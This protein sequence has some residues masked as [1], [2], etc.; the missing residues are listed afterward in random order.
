LAKVFSV[1][2]LNLSSTNED[3]RLTNTKLSTT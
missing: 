2:N 3:S 1:G